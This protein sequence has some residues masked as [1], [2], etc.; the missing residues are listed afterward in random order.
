MGGGGL[1]NVFAC[2]WVLVHAC[3]LRFVLNVSLDECYR[4]FDSIVN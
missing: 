3:E 2:V 1:K 4:D